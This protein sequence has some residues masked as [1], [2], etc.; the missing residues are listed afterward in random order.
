MFNKGARPFETF[1]KGGEDVQHS[2]RGEGI[3]C[4]TR[5]G[6]VFNVR[7]GRGGRSTF[8]KGGEAIR[9]SS[10]EGRVF[11]VRQS[12]WLEGVE[13][14]AET[15]VHSSASPGAHCALQAKHNGR[16]AGAHK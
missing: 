9:H 13:W 3:R 10:R 1:N 5:E 15:T 16:D 12:T 8:D 6:R 14:S 2:T 4:S 7:Q 11:Y